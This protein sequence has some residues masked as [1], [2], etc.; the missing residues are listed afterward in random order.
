MDNNPVTRGPSSHYPDTGRD[1]PDPRADPWDP[2]RVELCPPATTTTAF[3]TPRSTA[4][5]R[6]DPSGIRERKMRL[7]D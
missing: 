2:G 6:H 4:T 1:M 7:V 5:P 3:S